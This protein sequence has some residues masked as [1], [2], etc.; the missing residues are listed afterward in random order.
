MSPDLYT[1]VRDNNHNDIYITTYILPNNDISGTHILIRH[2][3]ITC[4]PNNRTEH[5]PG[6]A[7]A[8][9]LSFLGKCNCFIR[10]WHP[11]EFCQIT[12]GLLSVRY[13]TRK[14]T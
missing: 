5:F 13:I 11:L 12:L 9:R 6:I 10:D 2:A 7:T 14:R 4:F 1:F 8:P 3:H